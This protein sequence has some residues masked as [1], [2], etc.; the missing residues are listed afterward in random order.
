MERKSAIGARPFGKTAVPT[1][2]VGPLNKIQVQQA[3]NKNMKLFNFE[4]EKLFTV[5]N[6]ADFKKIIQNGFKGGTDGKMFN[7]VFR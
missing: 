6:S 1:E 3:L 7:G 4:Q 5:V 2:V